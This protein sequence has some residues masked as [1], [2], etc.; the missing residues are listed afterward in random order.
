VE[1]FVGAKF[2]WPYAIA[3]SNQ[4]IR[5]REKTLLSTLSEYLQK[6][7]TTYLQM[8]PLEKV[9]EEN[10]WEPTNPGSLAI[11]PFIDW[12]VK[13]CT[14]LLSEISIFIPTINNISDV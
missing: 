6:N 11:R 2:S 8:L 10:Q 7:H 5:I 3:D 14:L 12:C 13:S 1:D 9:K 4:C